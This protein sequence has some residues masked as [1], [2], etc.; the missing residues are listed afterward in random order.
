MQ[1]V[2]SVRLH[3]LPKARYI[4][5]VKKPYSR[6]RVP[7]DATWIKCSAYNFPKMCLHIQFPKTMSSHIASIWSLTMRMSIF[8]YCMVKLREKCVYKIDYGWNVRE[9]L[10]LGVHVLIEKKICGRICLS[11]KFVEHC[12]TMWHSSSRTCLGG[13]YAK[14]KCILLACAMAHVTTSHIK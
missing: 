2:W 1:H 10:Q 6:T 3:V 7:I 8:M 4:Y 14:W 13:E 5:I 11:W 12:N 9:S